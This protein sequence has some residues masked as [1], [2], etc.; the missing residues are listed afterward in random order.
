MSIDIRTHAVDYLFDA[1]L[2]LK[3]REE[4][5]AFFEDIC[6]V[7]EILSLSQRFEVAAMLRSKKTYLEIAD[8][9][10]AST[11]TISRVNRSLNYGKD[12]YDLAFSRIPPLPEDEEENKSE[13]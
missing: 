6:T 11:A 10:G 1:I 2:S 9:T 12:G 3:D 7:N 13:K 5:Y 8:K 4:C